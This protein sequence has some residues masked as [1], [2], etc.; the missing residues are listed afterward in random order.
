[1]AAPAPSVG[2]PSLLLLLGAVAVVS[3]AA[4]TQQPP[5][6]TPPAAQPPAAAAAAG[7]D[8]QAT[9]AAPADA[10][11]P[12]DSMVVDSAAAMA[13]T[14]AAPAPTPA[15]APTTWPVDP[16]TG[17]TLINGVPVVGRVFIMRKTDGLVKVET[18][19][20]DRKNEAMAPEA[21]IVDDHYTPL[22]LPNTRRIRTIMVQATLWG[23]DTKR[24]AVERRFYRPV[25]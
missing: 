14:M 24:S 3:I 12:V 9:A 5:T 4:R 21:P 18:V 17:Q 11:A 25:Q 2:R 7:A 6:A 13:V 15:P 16:V 19:A 23:M 10:S 1:M 8:S 22:P 20:E